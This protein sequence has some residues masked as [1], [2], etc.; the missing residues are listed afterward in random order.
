MRRM[1]YMVL[2]MLGLSAASHAAEWVQIY[3]FGSFY[4]GTTKSQY[5]DTWSFNKFDDQ[6]GDWT[7]QSVH[8]DFVLYAWGGFIGQDNDGTTPLYSDEVGFDVLGN[9]T[10]TDVALLK[11]ETYDSSW[12]CLIREEVVFDLA[13]DDGDGSGYQTG[14]DDWATYA[15]PDE[16]NKLVSSLS[17]DI[18]S[19]YISSFI[20]SGTFDM[21]LSSSQ[22][23]FPIT[24]GAAELVQTPMQS[25]GYVRVT[26]DFISEPA[27]VGLIGSCGLMMLLV[28]RIRRRAA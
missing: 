10:S 3:D 17:S 4:P 23:S 6:D 5:T 22:E 13:A 8:L 26:Y 14:G 11:G 12:E 2:F 21:N 16:E 25:G 28:N 19:M 15:A 7:L 1:V 27:A 9:I 20:G 24:D 18:N